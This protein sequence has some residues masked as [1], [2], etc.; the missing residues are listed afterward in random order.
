[1]DNLFLILSQLGISGTGGVLL[2]VAILL[3]SC[4]F[5]FVI[6]LS[7]FRW[8]LGIRG[9]TF[10]FVTAGL[11]LA[12]SYYVMVPQIEKSLGAA[13]VIL[14][15]VANPPDEIRQRAFESAA[16]SWKNFLVKNTDREVLKKFTPVVVSNADSTTASENP[17]VSWKSAAPAFLLSELKHATRAAL[18]IILPFLVIDLLLA[19]LLTGLGVEN[20]SVAV[21]AVP[22]KLLLLVAVDGWSLIADGLIK[23][24]GG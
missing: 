21:I 17:V 10:G 22:V 23:F 13:A 7:V 16:E 18:A 9:V 4:F 2:L 6:V 12:L 20:L 15:K 11:A 1:M 14:G 24:Y 19:L 3:F 5:R 8:G